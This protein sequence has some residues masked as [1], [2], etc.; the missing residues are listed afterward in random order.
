MLGPS[1]S[2]VAVAAWLLGTVAWGRPVLTQ[3]TPTS[4]ITAQ[5]E[6]YVAA[7]NRGDVRGVADLYARKPGVSSA[8]DG[9]V[10]VGWSQILDLYRS[11]MERF[12]RVTMSAESLTV[13]PV[14]SDGAVA[15]FRYRWKGVRGRDTTATDGAMTLVYE[16]TAQGWRIVHDHTS[17]RRAAGGA[18]A[19]EEAPAGPGREA[20]VVPGPA[21]P[22]EPCVVQRIVDGDTFDCVGGPRVR[23]IGMDAPERSQRPFG[24]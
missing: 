9:E 18:G 24:T 11:F 4:E 21:G 7:V 5:V 10:T 12:G 22:T 1:L 20:G 6:R 8:G 16:R 23:M 19:A 15:T 14:G 17:T 13:A 2:S 3:A